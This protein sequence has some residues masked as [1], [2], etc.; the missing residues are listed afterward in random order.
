MQSNTEKKQDTLYQDRL[1]RSELIL[2]DQRSG[3][4]WQIIGKMQTGNT[5]YQTQ[6]T[7]EKK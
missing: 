5:P 6:N 2:K 1:R 3:V 7:E 4:Y